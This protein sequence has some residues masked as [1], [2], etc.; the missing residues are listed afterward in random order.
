M[1]RFRQLLLP[2]PPPLDLLPW[3][4]SL[5]P[6]PLEP[7]PFGS[8]ALCLPF[9]QSPTRLEVLRLPSIPNTHTLA[10]SL[11]HRNP[12]ISTHSFDCVSPTLDSISSFRSVQ[13]TRYRTQTHPTRFGNITHH[14]RIDT[15]ERK[16]CS[17][18]PG[19]IPCRTVPYRLASIFHDARLSLVQGPYDLL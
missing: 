11:I 1:V 4:T 15:H 13:P 8:S 12:T 5:G 6:P 19:V 9:V 7:P 2:P 3:T 10:R 17:E 18:S 16:C 14:I